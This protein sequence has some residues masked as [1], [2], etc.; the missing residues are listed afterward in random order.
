M[1]RYDTT[2]TLRDTDALGLIYFTEQLNYCNEAFQAFLNHNNITL[3][4]NPKKAPFILPIVHCESDYTQPLSLND[5]VTIKIDSI[6]VGLSSMSLNYSIWKSDAKVGSA[7]IT[8][9]CVNTTNGKSMP[10]PN[11]FKELLI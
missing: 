7:L 9:V 8:H 5:K 2:V 4:I 1:F 3:S 11:E 10:L 6:N